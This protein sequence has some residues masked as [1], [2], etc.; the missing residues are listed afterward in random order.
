MIG[1]DDFGKVRLGQIKMTFMF[2]C[3]LM[4]YAEIFWENQ[5]RFGHDMNG[6]KY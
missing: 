2:F 4:T 1:H 6:Y 3:P 5:S